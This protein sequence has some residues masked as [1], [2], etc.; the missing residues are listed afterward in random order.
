MRWK[1]IPHVL[2]GEIAYNMN[3]NTDYNEKILLNSFH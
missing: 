2:R 1:D 3:M